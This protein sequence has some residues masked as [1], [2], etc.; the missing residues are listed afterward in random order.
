MKVFLDTNVLTSALATRGL[1][2]ELF[3]AVLSEQQLV[4]SDTVL[5][6]LQRILKLIFNLPETIIT[7][8]I[9][10]ISAE[11]LIGDGR[12][13]LDGIP[14]PDDAAILAAAI[15][16]NASHFVTGDKALLGLKKINQMSIISP[17]ELW[18]VLSHASDMP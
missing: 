17:R 6:E 13:K 10:Q 15:E 1:C 11:A 5:S 14:D 8:Y 3:I 4:S 2:H 7:S 18:Q 9:E 12:N 16:A